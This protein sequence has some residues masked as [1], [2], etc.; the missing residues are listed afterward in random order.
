MVTTMEELLPLVAEAKT[1]REFGAI[2]LANCPPKLKGPLS[3]QAR[4]HFGWDYNDG[5]VAYWVSLGSHGEA[6]KN[7]MNAT[8]A[9]YDRANRLEGLIR[10][11]KASS[12]KRG[13][14]FTEADGLHLR[15]LWADAQAG[16]TPWVGLLDFEAYGEVRETGNAGNPWAPS[17][18][19]LDCSKG[20]WQGNVVVAPNILNKTINRFDRRLTIELIAKAGQ[21]E[22][23]DFSALRTARLG[24][25]PIHTL[26][27]GNGANVFQYH[28][29]LKPYQAEMMELTKQALYR[30]GTCAVTGLAFVA[31]QG[32]PCL[33]SWDLIDQSKTGKRTWQGTGKAARCINT[34]DGTE[35]PEDMRLV[36][37]FF[38][39]GR[40]SWQDED[41]WKM[42]NRVRE[43]VGAGQIDSLLTAPF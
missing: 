30:R 2:V 34:E 3:R 5:L 32:H 43:I 17:F 39:H 18:D 26:I 37:R 8:S 9:A 40:C 1:C 24:G 35:R 7:R 41:W 25:K 12:N 29:A 23:P 16:D 4:D 11:C 33:P 13:H 27:A 42:A 10:S 19:R 22:T 14:S 31:E 28:P 15:S 36:C 38:N 6:R 20:Y 21:L